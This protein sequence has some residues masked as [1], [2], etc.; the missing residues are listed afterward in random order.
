[1]SIGLGAVFL[2]GVRAAWFFTIDDASITFRYSDNLAAGNGPVWNVDGNPVE[3]FTNFLW[4]VWHAPFAWLGLD[5]PTVAKLTSVLAGAATLVLL[6]RYCLR[7][8]GIV[9]ALVAGGAYVVFLP[10]YFHIT[11]G[12]ETAAFA[13]LVLRAV[14]VGLYALERRPVRVWEPPLLLLLA[15]MLRPDGVLAALPAFTAW[16]WIS[17]RDRRVW[18]WTAAAVAAGLGYFAWRWTYYGYPFPNTFYVKFGNVTAGTLWL[19]RTAWLFAP[20]LTLTVYLV[21]RERTRQAGLLLCGTV[22]LTYLT[23][24]MSGPTMDYLHRFAFH[25]FPV[26]CLGTGL[27]VGTVRRRRLAS[28]FGIVAVSW[29]AIAGVQTPDL[30]LIANYGPDLAR[31]HVPIG[32]GLAR[33]DV[34]DTYRTIA[35]HDAGATPYYSS[36]RTIDYIGLN[37]E[38]IAHGADVTRFVTNARPTVIVV[39]SIMRPAPGTAYGMS[40]PVATRGYEHIATV[41]MRQSYYLHVYALP[42]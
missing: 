27:A 7:R 30:G 35:V 38:T 4:V 20:F 34:P 12:L 31:A 17:R 5:L 36:W 22:A 24:L 10:T 26:L 11:G 8:S 9:A 41:Q 32:Q 40:V 14:I 29:V 1:M 15:G 18:L 25:A 6:A 3:G 37:D 16:L 33:A 28:G 19:D 13:A 21:L 2:L 39:R 23:Y 42:E